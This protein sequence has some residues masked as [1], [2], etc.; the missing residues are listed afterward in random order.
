MEEVAACFSS[1]IAALRDESPFRPA[2][3]HP[4]SPAP[5]THRKP[6][7]FFLWRSLM[8]LALAR[9]ERCHDRQGEALP[10]P[11]AGFSI[12]CGFDSRRERTF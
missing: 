7:F 2:A 9:A 6:F 3:S 12:R 10:A 1:L 5:V 4:D 11:I 8:T